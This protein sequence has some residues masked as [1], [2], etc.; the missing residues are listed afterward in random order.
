M[1]Q[2][3]ISLIWCA[4]K[5]RRSGPAQYSQGLV[6]PL[7]DATDDTRLLTRAATLGLGL[8]FKPGY[9]YKKAGIMLTLLSDK[10]ELNLNRQNMVPRGCT[11]NQL[12]AVA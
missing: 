3:W 7:P 9:K 8:I 1:F 4:N 6:V 11:L 2:H 10:G 12:L 5:S